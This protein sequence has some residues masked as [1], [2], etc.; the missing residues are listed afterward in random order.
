MLFSA[1][2]NIA[3]VLNSAFI[4]LPQTTAPQRKLIALCHLFDRNPE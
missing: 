3:M 4:Q 2:A 1:P